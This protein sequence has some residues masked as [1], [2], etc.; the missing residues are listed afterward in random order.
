MPPHEK[1]LSTR[2]RI[3]NAAER[4]ILGQGYTATS[5][6]QIIE[7]VGITKGAF[8]YHFPT[9]SDLAR[10]LIE[11]YAKAD[12][13]LLEDNF[14]RAERL[15][16]DPLQ[17]LLI[18]LGLLIEVLEQAPEAPGCLFAAYVY[19]SGQFDEE[20]HRIIAT[21]VLRWRSRLA[22]KLRVIEARHP[23]RRPIDIDS[24][25]DMLTGVLEGAYI[26]ARVLA[27]PGAL[28]EQLRHYRTYVELLFEDAPSV[29]Q[30]R[31]PPR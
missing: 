13:A 10:S 12:A 23:P 31:R 9:K 15:S 6:D 22:A 30:K 21:A 2:E 25:A 28:A 14:A 29:P 3:E 1:G 17:Q 7:A 27:H 8:F 5:V 16:D 18:F 4:L 19:E 26:L 11:R 20:V 24:L